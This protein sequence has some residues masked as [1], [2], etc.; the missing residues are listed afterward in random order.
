M[1]VQE[2]IPHNAVILPD[3][4]SGLEVYTEADCRRLFGQLVDAV[5]AF[6]NAGA[7]HRY[8]HMNNIIMDSH[9]SSYVLLFSPCLAEFL[10][11]SLYFVQ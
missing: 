9:V 2:M 10:I 7:A 4:I 11:D 3:F 5:G 6:H 8:L 1:L